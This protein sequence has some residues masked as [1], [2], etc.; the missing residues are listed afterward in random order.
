M[1]VWVLSRYG[2]P[3]G[4][5]TTREKAQHAAECMTALLPGASAPNWNDNY[6][7]FSFYDE[8]YAHVNTSYWMIEEMEMNQYRK[9]G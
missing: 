3:K 8:I 1:I 6:W 5:F 4:V 2:K 7:V 9:R